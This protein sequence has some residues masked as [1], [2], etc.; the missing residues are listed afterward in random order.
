MPKQCSDKEPRGL[1]SVSR[2]YVEL[3][4]QK[5]FMDDLMFEMTL[6]RVAVNEDE[7][8][9]N[10]HLKPTLCLKSSEQNALAGDHILTLQR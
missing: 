5:D 2:D 6:G 10:A 8:E 4:D 7:G 1:V 9:Q 3:E